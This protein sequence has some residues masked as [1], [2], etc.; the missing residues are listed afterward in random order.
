MDFVIYDVILLVLFVLFVSFFLYIKRNNLKREGL[1][2]LY[3]TSWGIKLINSVGK[4]YSKTL[5]VLSY[6]SII[7]GYLLMAGM[8]YLF[9]K[10]VWLYAFTDIATTINIPPIL[11]LVPYLDKIVPSLGFPPFYFTYWIIILAVIAITHEFT[12][13]IFAAYNKIKIKTTGFGFFPFFLPILLAAFVEL[14]EKRMTKK[15]KFSQMAVLSAG[16]FANI[17]TA[18]FFFVLLLI[19]F[20]LAFLSAGVIY[21]SYSY[22][23]INIS[24]ISTLNGVLLGSSFSYSDIINIANETGF[25]KIK[26]EDNRSY[27]I[28]KESLENQKD[29]LGYIIAY[30]DAPAINS[31][32][33]AIIL[34]VNGKKVTSVESFRRELIK[35]SPGDKITL[36]TKGD[37][38]EEKEIILGENPKN[39]SLPFLGI[40]FVNSD[41]GSITGKIFMVFSSFKETNVYYEPKFDGISMFVYNLL[42]WL[43]LISI[44]VALV[45]MLPMG[46]FDGGRF[47]YLTMLAITRNERIAKKAFSFMSFFLFFLVLVIVFIW[48]LSLI[49]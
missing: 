16:T 10:I 7:L 29:N 30:D 18:V 24:D 27:L 47:F 5:K 44:S 33:N 9:G 15:S 46:I 38:V 6:F 49:R 23:A 4:K 41:S 20:S 13:G 48:I 34:D 42:W 1:L 22:S 35:Y 12:H 40:A 43:I 3:R 39:E 11:P 26:T 2:F 32:L 28:T 21:N 31:K 8:I 25:N 19:F 37:E 36:K 14:D 17:L 45:N